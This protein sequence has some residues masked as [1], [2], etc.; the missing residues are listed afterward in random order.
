[1]LPAVLILV[2][3]D[4]CPP[5]RRKRRNFEGGKQVLRLRA[6]HR[7]IAVKHKLAGVRIDA[8]PELHL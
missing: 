1:M 8:A 5:N 6:L 3:N 4:N 2:A 7:E